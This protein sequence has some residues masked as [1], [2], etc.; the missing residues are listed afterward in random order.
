[1]NIKSL[2]S[3]LF[4]ASL[5]FISQGHF[6]YAGGGFVDV[7]TKIVVVVA[8][9]GVAILTGGA[10]AALLLTVIPAVG[11]SLV[12][13]GI[14]LGV[15]A[16]TFLVVGDCV[17]GAPAETDV[18]VFCGSSKPGTG[19]PAGGSSLPPTG[20]VAQSQGSAT[21]DS[22]TLSIDPQ[23]HN[24]SYFRD[25]VLIKY[26][27]SDQGTFTDTGLTPHTNYSYVIRIPDPAEAG[28]ETSDTAPFAAYTKC[29]PQCSFAVDN[30]NVAAYGTTNLRWKCIH[31]DPVIDNGGCAITDS[32][33]GSIQ[34]VDAKSGTWD[35]SPS[36]T[37][38]Y[39]L[40]CANID[41][42][43][44]VPQNINIFEPGIKEVKP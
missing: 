44:S 22:Y 35:V 4:V 2:A 7:I 38:T 10:A 20:L 13:A 6:A 8:I 3:F 16:T 31:N 37:T 9:V 41:G 21:C 29:L 36:T 27:T 42:A 12:G 25:G 30:P 23:G 5:I 24:F 32:S 11:A 1:M 17:P 43:I 14:V 26:L 39:T 33:T 15:I 19:G 28:V 40:K 18:N 34:T